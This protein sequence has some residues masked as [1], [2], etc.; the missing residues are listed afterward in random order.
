MKKLPSKV[1][2]FSIIE[3]TFLYWPDYPNGKFLFS[4]VAYK[5][6]VYKTGSIGMF[7]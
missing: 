4:N 6:S 5:A 7:V 3:E 2:Y 1:S